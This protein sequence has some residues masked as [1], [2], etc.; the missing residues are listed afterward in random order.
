MDAPTNLRWG[1]IPN[2]DYSGVD[3]R[4]TMYWDGVNP[5]TYE[6]GD[7]CLV[8]KW[9]IEIEKDGQFYSELY[10]VEALYYNGYWANG[11]FVT[12]NELISM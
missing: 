1:N 8:S 3:N 2:E 11:Q 5:S 12:D 4:Y 7:G 9:I 10:G 6:F